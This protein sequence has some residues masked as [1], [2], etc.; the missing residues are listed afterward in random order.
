VFAGSPVK[1]IGRARFLRN[2][3]I[4][5]GNTRDARLADAARARLDDAAPLVRGAAVWALGRLIGAAALRRE[6]RAD[7]DATV[8][9]EW[10]AATR[11]AADAPVPT[12]R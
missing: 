2:V 9:E 3:L 1:R 7:A 8:A 10:A 6:A 4:A 12:P 11:S 5:I